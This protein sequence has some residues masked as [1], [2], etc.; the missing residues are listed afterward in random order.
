MLFTCDS[1]NLSQISTELLSHYISSHASDNDFS[2][3]GLFAVLFLSHGSG[4]RCSCQHTFRS[5]GVHSQHTA[6]VSQGS[7]QQVRFLQ[8]LQK[9]V[10]AYLQENV[11]ITRAAGPHRSNPLSSHI[12][13]RSQTSYASQWKEL[14]LSSA[15]ETTNELSLG[16]AASAVRY[17]CC[18]GKTLLLRTR[19]ERTPHLLNSHHD[20]A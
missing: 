20:S 15:C 11:C 14:V 17:M 8:Y 12:T 9:Q 13:A 7:H 6:G 4:P 1:S 19:H 2:V 16:T 5:S 18:V 3:F 10:L